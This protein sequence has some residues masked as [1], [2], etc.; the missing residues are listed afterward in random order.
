[1]SESE[2]GKGAW[3]YWL[4]WIVVI[5]S[6]MLNIFLFY[7]LYTTRQRVQQE[8]ANVALAMDTVQ[9][10]NFDLPIEINETLPLKME[11][12]YNDTFEVP[13][14]TTIPVSTSIVVND[15]IALPI[16][17]IVSINRDIRVAIAVLG[18]EIPIDIPLR[19]DIPI[20]LFIDVPVN[21]EVPV[22]T[23]I[24]L[25]LM[26]EV[27]VDTVIPIDTEVPVQFA[28]PVTIPLDQFG[29]NELLQ[30]LQDGLNSL[31]DSFGG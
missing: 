7:G 25:D 9:L 3:H 19:A 17:D 11:V 15:N 5:F 22:E 6:L 4:L 26:V 21:L 16:N 28:F 2:Y 24:P 31:A 14:K 13:I 23:E 30:K 12:A 10:E 18:Q 1:M 27:P 20:D 8:I 29:I